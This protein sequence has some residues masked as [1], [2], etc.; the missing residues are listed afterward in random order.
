M[1]NQKIYQK[2]TQI[3]DSS[4][5]SQVCKPERLDISEL[6]SSIKEYMENEI[7]VLRYLNRRNLPHSWF[8][9]SQEYLR[10]SEKQCLL[11]PIKPKTNILIHKGQLTNGQ[12]N[13]NNLERY[14][15][16]GSPS[17][18]SPTYLS[19]INQALMINSLPDCILAIDSKRLSEK[20]SVFIDPET[21]SSSN[22]SIGDSY[23]ILGGIPKEAIIEVLYNKKVFVNS[24]YPRINLHNKFANY[25]PIKEKAKLKKEYEEKI[26]SEWNNLIISLRK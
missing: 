17:E 15:I 20:R 21:I 25:N 13:I 10:I 4:E 3:L 8:Y 23:F 24:T 26:D 2:L 9:N 14:A 5:E 19:E 11:F 7:K 1:Q 12:N 18:K 22:E 6:D 16:F